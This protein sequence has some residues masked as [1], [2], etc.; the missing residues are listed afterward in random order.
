MASVQVNKLASTED[1]ASAK[2]L[3]KKWPSRIKSLETAPGRYKFW[4]NEL[5]RR[6][7]NPNHGP[8]SLW[9]REGNTGNR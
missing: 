1:S 8:N 2:S 6:L 4:G 7:C 9:P 3:T 5:N